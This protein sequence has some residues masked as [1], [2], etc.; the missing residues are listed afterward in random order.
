MYNLLF[1]TLNLCAVYKFCKRIAFLYLQY[2]QCTYIFRK[3][4]R[5]ELRKSHAT[6]LNNLLQVVNTSHM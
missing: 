3:D 1:Y 2:V 6:T 4:I 5:K